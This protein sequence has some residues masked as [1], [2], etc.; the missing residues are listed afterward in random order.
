MTAMHRTTIGLA[1]LV[2]TACGP[3]LKQHESFSPDRVRQIQFDDSCELAGYMARRRPLRPK[4]SFS[5]GIGDG[6]ARGKARYKI[7]KSSDI[8]EFW[9][10][11]RRYYQDVPSV[12]RSG[13]IVATVRYAREQQQIAMPIG[14][15]IEVAVG[16]AQFELPYHPCLGA[17]FLGDETYRI[18]RRVLREAVASGEG[19]A[20]R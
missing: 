15:S 17:F 2:C 20:E 1:A 13:E 18:R 8:E 5:L 11:V 12:S 14:A 16:E 10:I 4:Q 6:S 7:D 19:A 9:R 3:Q